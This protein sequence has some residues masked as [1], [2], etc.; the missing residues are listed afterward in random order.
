VA[1]VGD[2][3]TSRLARPWHTVTLVA[4]AVALVLQLV[5]ILQGQTTVDG[6]VASTG[7]E[8]VR[9]YF[10]YFTIQSNLLVAVSTFL[11]VTG[12]SDG[13]A[14]SV[15][16][17]ASLVG[18]TVTG[19]VAAVALPPSPSYTTA[20]LLC[21]RLLHVAVPL[22]TVVGW[23][24]FGPRGRA[25]MRDIA[26]ALAWPVVWLVATLS[27]G[28]VAGWYPYPFLNVGTLGFPRVLVTCLLVAVLF[29]GLCALAVGL[30]YRLSR[31]SRVST[32]TA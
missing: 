13:R 21:D 30:D 28:P 1:I 15:V 8:A 10:S 23:V 22:L 12:R 31:R 32:P 6:V 9:R 19:V 16:R 20:N 17:L 24:A 2:M 29:V 18:I 5:L 7:A 26:P 14:F 25:T 4:A 3:S 11:I 27:L